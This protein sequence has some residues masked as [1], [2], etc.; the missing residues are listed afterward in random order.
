[1]QNNGSEGGVEIL[2]D[3]WQRSFDKALFRDEKKIGSYATS[4]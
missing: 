1:M 2:F 4:D 3:E